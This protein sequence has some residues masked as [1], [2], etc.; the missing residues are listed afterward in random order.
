M[1]DFKN[2]QKVVVYGPGFCYGKLRGRADDR[3]I[4]VVREV[5]PDEGT[6]M[7]RSED[8]GPGTVYGVRCSGK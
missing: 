5:V 1:N 6:M 3:W 2:G 8:G 7:V 4:G